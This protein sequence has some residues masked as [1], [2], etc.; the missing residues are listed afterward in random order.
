M[1]DEPV[2]A[3]DVSVR[4]QILNLLRR[5]AAPPRDGLPVH[6]ATTSSVVRH[7]CDRVAV[8]YLGRIVELATRDALF[9]APMHPY[10]GR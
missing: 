9:A 1:C 4:A 8:M 2:S 5:A 10:T 7:V 3:L 6:L